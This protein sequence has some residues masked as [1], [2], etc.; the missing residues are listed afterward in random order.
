MWA[1]ENR[2]AIL[3][4]DARTLFREALA[5]VLLMEDDF[6]VVGEAGDLA[7]A[8]AIVLS[9][10]PEVILVD[11]ELPVEEVADRVRRL[12]QAAPRSRIILLSMND[13]PR[14]VQQVLSL[15]INGYLPK[16]T[17]R[18]ELASAIRGVYGNEGKM[19]LSVSADSLL[20]VEE[21]EDGPLSPRER[22][23]LEFVAQGLSNA[24]IASRLSIVEGTVKRHLRNI[25]AKLGAQSRI[26]AVNKAAAAGLI[27]GTRGDPADRRFGAAGGAGANVARSKTALS[28]PRAG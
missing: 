4:V 1:L 7:T 2:I 25:F 23:V 9:V 3:L 14:F 20:S 15:D 27:S 5:Q 13:N 19:V 12:R 28:P 17:N 11:A 16:D 18:H 26:D 10:R 21:P 6:A 22:E 8:L 24:Q